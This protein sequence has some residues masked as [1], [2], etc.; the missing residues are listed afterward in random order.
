MAIL[1]DK[2]MLRRILEGFNH[3][4]NTYEISDDLLELFEEI[5]MKSFSRIKDKRIYTFSQFMTLYSSLPLK[6]LIP[7]DTTKSEEIK[8]YHHSPIILEN[9]SINDEIMH[10]LN[11]YDS[12][13]DLYQKAWVPVLKYL[14]REDPRSIKERQDDYD[15]M[16]I[17]LMTKQPLIK[18]TKYYSNLTTKFVSQPLLMSLMEGAYK[19]YVEDRAIICSHCKYPM[20]KLPSGKYQCVGHYIC[21]HYHS[22][23][24]V[25]D[26]KSKRHKILHKGFYIFTT[27]PSL[28]ELEV[29]QKLQ[30]KGFKTRRHPELEQLGD[31]EVLLPNG[32]SVYLDCKVHQSAYRLFETLEKDPKSKDMHFYILPSFL[33]KN[34]YKSQLNKLNAKHRNKYNFTTEK[35]ISQLLMAE[36]YQNRY[37]LEQNINSDEVEEH[38]QIKLF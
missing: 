10:F 12:L 34:E 8:F 1:E 17:E 35:R 26:T 30:S 18:S 14:R 27:L 6:Q 33:Y 32:R 3:Y 5:R 2:A 22:T 37:E 19:D 24:I 21:K 29:E 38:E 16:R 4:I 11:D 20:E 25:I 31:I 7:F 36:N 28:F 9:G 23:G 15:L 13:E